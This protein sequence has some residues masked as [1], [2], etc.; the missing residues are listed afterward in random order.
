LTRVE[1]AMQEIVSMAEQ[2][3]D[4][5]KQVSMATGQQKDASEQVVMTM[6]ELSDVSRQMAAAAGE[7]TQSAN[8]LTQ[9]TESLKK[10]ISRFKLEG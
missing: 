5:A 6:H 3:T 2:T 8:S 1:K 10:I 4:S 9:M 7:T